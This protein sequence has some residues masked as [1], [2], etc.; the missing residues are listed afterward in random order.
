MKDASSAGCANRWY[1]EEWCADFAAW[2]WR[3]AGVT[4]TYSYSGSNINAW[5]ASFYAW[6]LA[7]GNW[8]S[9]SSGYQP[10]PG[11]VAVYGE[12]AEASGGGSHVGIYV[13]GSAG[14]PTVVNG[15]WGYP[16]FADVYE[17]TNERNTGPGGG[18]LDG[19]VSVPN[20]VGVP[21]KSGG[22]T[23]PS[24]SSFTSSQESL[25]GS[26]GQFYP[27]S[28]GVGCN[29][30]RIHVDDRRHARPHDDPEHVWRGHR[31]RVRVPRIPP[32]HRSRLVSQLSR[33]DLEVRRARTC[34]LL[35]CPFL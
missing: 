9:L 20:Q 13:S 17:Q 8:H 19:Y 24:I 25:P 30:V 12:L 4:F 3:Q 32:P 27:L 16:G 5:A 6:G 1:D 29:V 35:N 15:D 7:T 31:H 34:L 10:Q 23:A 18:T 11:D 21:V 22:P 33:P 2:V 14:A 26:G 28:V